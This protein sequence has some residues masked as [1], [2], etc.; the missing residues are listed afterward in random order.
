MPFPSDVLLAISKRM[1]DSSW[2]ILQILKS[3]ESLAILDL[4][5]LSQLKQSKFSTELARLDGA[6][7]IEQ[8]KD[9]KDNRR[10]FVSINENGLAIMSYRS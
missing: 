1:T 9:P 3:K 4:M 2:E 5:A 8:Q 10:I 7:L 6:A